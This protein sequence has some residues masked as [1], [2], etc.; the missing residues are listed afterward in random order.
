MIVMV[1]RMILPLDDREWDAL[2]ADLEK[3]PSDEQAEYVRKAVRLADTFN[4][5]YDD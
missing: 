5:S 4:V 2:V 3:G 1:M